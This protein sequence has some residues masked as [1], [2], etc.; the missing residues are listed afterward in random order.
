[1]MIRTLAAAASASVLAGLL[2]GPA[3]AHD[4][5]AEPHDEGGFLIAWGHPGEDPGRYDTDL[6]TAGALLDRDGQPVALERIVS[7]DRVILRPADSA[8]RA[9]LARF[10]YA[11]G[12]T[13]QTSEGRYTRGSKTGHPGY[14]RAFYSVR[15][16]S[17]LTGWADAFARP[18]GFELEIVPV[19]NPYG[20]EGDWRVR[21][22]HNGTPLAGNEVVLKDATGNL[23]VQ[24]TD[25][26]GEAA[27]A[28]LP[29]SNYWLS[30][31]HDI[32]L[33][34]D[35][36]VDKRRLDTNLHV[37]QAAGAAQ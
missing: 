13:I 18:A 29:D 16:G 4:A 14:R 30:A 34:S 23:D 7:D 17:T 22:L 32:P 19:G 5:W 6:V 37:V 36:D 25:A 2:A 12:A 15:S 21:L 20:A 31:V 28:A 33:V 35:P 24:L 3:L 27:F 10:V 26:R 11:P 8:D 1:M 9:V